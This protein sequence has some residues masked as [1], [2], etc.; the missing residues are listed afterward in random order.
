MVVRRAMGSEFHSDL[1][2]SSGTR[3]DK[4]LDLPLSQPVYM[5]EGCP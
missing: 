5:E 4:V 1:L 2:T 3:D